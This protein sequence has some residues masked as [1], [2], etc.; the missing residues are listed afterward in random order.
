SACRSR[1]LATARGSSSICPGS[2]TLSV[3]PHT[4]GRKRLRKRTIASGGSRRQSGNRFE[5]ARD[6]RRSAE[7]ERPAGLRRQV[8]TEAYF[9]RRLACSRRSGFWPDQGNVTK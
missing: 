8:A 6:R 5:S 3:Q 9:P 4:E 7:V 2:N 1:A